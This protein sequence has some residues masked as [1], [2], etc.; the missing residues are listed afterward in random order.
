ML[1]E[2]YEQPE[3]IENA[4]RGRLSDADSSAHFGGLNLDMQQLRHA[5]RIVLTACGTSYHAGLVGE[6][7]F[8][9]LARIP[10]SGVR[11]R[12]PLPQSADRPAPIVIAIAIRRNGRHLAACKSKRK[13]HQARAICSVAARSP[14]NRRWRH[15]HA[16][17]SRRREHGAH[18]RSASPSGRALLRSSGALGQIQGCTHALP[19]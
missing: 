15:L 3:A 8:E 2:I 13:G 12:V 18:R 6:Y 11:Q 9:E 14:A 19:A 4:M 1:K 7:L 17:R 10:G 5:E 16:D